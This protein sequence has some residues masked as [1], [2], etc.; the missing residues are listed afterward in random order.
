M[1]E[2]EAQVEHD[3]VFF[4][5]LCASSASSSFSMSA[6]RRRKDSAAECTAS[7]SD[8]AREGRAR[9]G[10]PSPAERRAVR[11]LCSGQGCTKSPG[12]SPV[13]GCFC[14]RWAWFFGSRRAK[15][16]AGPPLWCRAAATAA[17]MLT[18][19]WCHHERIR[20]SRR[21]RPAPVPRSTSSVQDKNRHNLKLRASLSSE[22]LVW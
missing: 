22:R 14:F 16:D 20:R 17:A 13:G 8:H 10:R 3:A 15:F 2:D 4:A 18:C 19:S 11:S 6:R 21:L 12:R 7:P 9:V 1:H 5:F